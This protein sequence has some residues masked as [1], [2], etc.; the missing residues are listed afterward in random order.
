MRTCLQ[1]QQ[2]RQDA[3]HYHLSLSP[4]L[5]SFLKQVMVKE[6]SISFAFAEMCYGKRWHISLSSSNYPIPNQKRRWELNKV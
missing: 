1:T 5:H 2:R 6:W 3:G 4:P